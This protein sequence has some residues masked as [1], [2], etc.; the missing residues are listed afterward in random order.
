ML[1]ANK[2]LFFC[3][4]TNKGYAAVTVTPQEVTSEFVQ[5]ANVRTRSLTPSGR[6][7]IRAAASDRGV[8]AWEK[9]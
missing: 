8:R 6:A 2:E 4:L 1:G 9:Q 7:V 5:F 3:D